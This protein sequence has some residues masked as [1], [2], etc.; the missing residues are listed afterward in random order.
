[1]ALLVFILIVSCAFKKHPA[2]FSDPVSFS[3]RHSGKFIYQTWQS[4]QLGENATGVFLVKPVRPEYRAALKETVSDYR[5][6]HPLYDPKDVV[7]LK[8]VIYGD[9]KNKDFI[10]QVVVIFDQDGQ[11]N[12]L[13]ILVSDIPDFQT[14]RRIIAFY[15]WQRNN[16]IPMPDEINQFGFSIFLSKYMYSQTGRLLYFQKN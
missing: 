7:G 6:P 14:Y 2:A 15:F 16:W 13:L 1:M 3:N 4:D 9:T 5:Y 8:G 11:T 10:R 12:L